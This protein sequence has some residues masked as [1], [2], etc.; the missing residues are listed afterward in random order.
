MPLRMDDIHESG[1]I[2]GSGVMVVGIGS[3]Q[4]MWDLRARV[5]LGA[6]AG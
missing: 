1:E 2:R 6:A 5:S 4:R 3:L